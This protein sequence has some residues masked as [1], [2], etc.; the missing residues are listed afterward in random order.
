MR[1]QLMILPLAATVSTVAWLFSV[2]ERTLRRIAVAEIPPS[3]RP[4]HSDERLDGAATA[5]EQVASVKEDD[6]WRI[7][8]WTRLRAPHRRGGRECSAGKDDR[9]LEKKDTLEPVENE[10]GVAKNFFSASVRR[11]IS[12]RINSIGVDHSD[13]AVGWSSD[14][15]DQEQSSSALDDASS[16]R[17]DGLGRGR[18]P[19]T[20]S[21]SR[22]L[23]QLAVMRRASIVS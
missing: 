10:P 22:Q 16:R 15:G 9:G 21:R 3:R 6:R 13:T 19:A 17:S 12:A 11:P 1:R 23:R 4:G 14:V 18:S 7:K 20:A 8:E 5:L 2:P